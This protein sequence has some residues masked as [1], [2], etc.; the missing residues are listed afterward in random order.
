MPPKEGMEILKEAGIEGEYE[1]IGNLVIGY[2]DDGKRDKAPRKPNY[3][4]CRDSQRAPKRPAGN[5]L[6]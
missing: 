2:D 5:N 3:V 6:S 1:G 4:H